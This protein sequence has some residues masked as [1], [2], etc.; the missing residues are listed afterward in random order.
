MA[1]LSEDTLRIIA[2]NRKFRKNYII[3]KKLM[4]NPKTPV[5]I[6]LN[7]LPN[8]TGQDLKLLTTNKNIPETLRTSAMRLQRQRS[9]TKA[10]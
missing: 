4:N 7:L 8:V 5:E 6:S 2:R 10:E 9:A 1:S 3:I